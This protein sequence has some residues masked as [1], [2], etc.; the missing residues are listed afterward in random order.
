M[1]SIAPIYNRFCS[2]SME[3]YSI[4]HST[5]TLE[6]FLYL[7][8]KNRIELLA[9]VRAFPG[10]RKYPHFNREVFSKKLKE[11]GIIYKHFPGLGGRRKPLKNSPNNG[12]RNRSFQAYADYMSTEEFRKALLKLE[13]CAK[14]KRTA[15]MCSEAVWWRC[16]RRLISDALTLKNHE[17]IHILSS[18]RNEEHKLNPAARVVQGDLFYPQS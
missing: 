3:I 9:D 2:Y 11:K 12:W 17:V 14:E 6:D 10:S 18:T 16:H 7:L 5:R 8:E 13:S 15:I 4:G 1:K